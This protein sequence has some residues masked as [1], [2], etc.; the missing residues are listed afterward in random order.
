MTPARRPDPLA[1]R[2]RG[3][4]LDRRRLHGRRPRRRAGARPRS[5]AAAACWSRLRAGPWVVQPDGSRRLLGGYGEATW[6]PRGLFVAASGGRTLSALEPDGT[7]RWS[8]SA[9]RDRQRSALVA[10]GL[11]IAYRAAGRAAGRRRRRHRG[12]AWW[13]ATWP[14]LPPAWSPLGLHLLAYLDGEGRLRLADPDSG[15][16]MGSAGAPRAR[17]SLPGRRTP[18]CCSRGLHGRS[19]CMRYAATSS[20]AA[21]TSARPT[22]VRTAARRDGPRR[23]L[24]AGGPARSPPC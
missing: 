1:R 2:R 6:S 9:R 10:V 12:P 8:L 22:R 4:R 24:L 18:R 5:P 13:T 14:S 15:T 7:P 19:G 16:T 20:S 11:P 21:L 23:R 17:S 3:A